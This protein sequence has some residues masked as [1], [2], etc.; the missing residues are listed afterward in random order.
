MVTLHAHGRRALSP[1]VGGAFRVT[2][3]IACCAKRVQRSMETAP[4]F[5]FC[6]VSFDKDT[7]AWC[8][9]IGLAQTGVRPLGVG[10]HFEVHG[11]LEPAWRA[12]GTKKELFQALIRAAGVQIKRNSGF[13]AAAA[14]MAEKPWPS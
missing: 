12:E 4:V 9:G 11:R 7:I 10:L 1:A 3:A 5:V 6:V 13:A 2:S 8:G 14:K